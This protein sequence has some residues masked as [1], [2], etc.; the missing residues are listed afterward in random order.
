MPTQ[1]VIQVAQ[2]LHFPTLLEFLLVLDN[3]QW[4]FK[5]VIY[6]GQDV[7]WK[8]KIVSSDRPSFQYALLPQMDHSIVLSAYS[9]GA[10]THHQSVAYVVSASKIPILQPEN[11]APSSACQLE[12]S[13]C[14]ELALS[15]S[16]IALELHLDLAI[17]AARPIYLDLPLNAS[18]HFRRFTAI[19][20]FK[21]SSVC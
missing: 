20:R 13:S 6:E 14:L 19:D 10:D 17:H 8:K 15:D 21:R 1:L 4:N 3:S 16:S 9:F 11:C 12:S 5:A 2:P 18:H 7:S